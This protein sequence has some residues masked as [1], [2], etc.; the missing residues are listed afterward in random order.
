ML[1]AMHRLFTPDAELARGERV[2]VLGEEA[3]HAARVKRCAEGDLLELLDGRG[4]IAIATVVAT[5]PRSRPKDARLVLEVDSVRIAEPDRPRLEVYAATPKAQRSSGMVDQLSQVGAAMWAPLRAT[6]TVV[7][8]RPTKLDR[9]ERVAGEAAKQ[10]ARPYL[11]EIG[12]AAALDRVLAGADGTLVVLADASGVAYEPS[13]AQTIR[14]LIGPEGGWTDDELARARDGGA[15]IASFG[16]YAMRI[17][18]AAVAAAA[19]ILERE[20]GASGGK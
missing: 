17:E 9:L 11:L 15:R 13:G 4:R 12:R 7:D 3:H 6:R 14:L 1:C 2:E 10:C 20:R 18:T 5:E 19:V 16:A 8:P